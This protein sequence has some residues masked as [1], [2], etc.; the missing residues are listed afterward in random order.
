[1]QTNTTAKDF[2]LHLGATVALYISVGA[3]INLVFAIINY[4]FPDQLS[5]YFYANT[6]AWPISMLVVLVPVL[7]VLEWL[8]KKDIDKVPEKKDIWVRRWRIYLTLFI[9]GAIMA[10]DLIALINTYLNGEI[11]IRFFYKF[12]ALLVIVGVVFTYYILS[13][14]WKAPKTRKTLAG[15]MIVIVLA[16]I[17]GGFVIAGSPTKQRDLRFDSQRTSDLQSIQWQVVNYW[18]QKGKLPTKLADLND[19]LYGTKVPTDPETEVDY[20]YT[21]KG[22]LSFQ[23][24]ATFARDYEDTKGRGAYGGGYYGGYGRIAAPDMVSYPSYPGGVADN[25]EYK[26]GK[27]CFDRTIDPEKYPKITPQPL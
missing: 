3:L 11:S 13:K 7:Y 21:T 20:E 19:A 9:G 27:T 25:W 16:S 5:G 22:Q 10:G 17:V 14:V 18:Q 1:M 12:L 15:A 6:V 2:F 4:S 26:A 23:L 24:C 8:I